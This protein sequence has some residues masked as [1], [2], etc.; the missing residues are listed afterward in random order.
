MVRIFVREPA[1]SQQRLVLDQ[2]I[3][4]RLIRVMRM[5]PG[6]SVEIVTAG[7]RWACKLESFS[8]NAAVVEI[9]H[10]LPAVP[11]GL[12]LVLAQA[13]PKGDRFEWL[14]EKATELGVS[15][16]VPLITERTIARPSGTE[17]KLQR[18]NKIAEQAAGQSENPYPTIV[19]PPLNLHEWI[20]KDDAELKC[21]LHEREGTGSLRDFLR[22]SILRAT[23]VV[24]PEGGWSNEEIASLVNAGYH[25]IH[26]GPR[27]LRSETAGLV[28]ASI[29]QYELGDFH[30]ERS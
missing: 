17:A 5:K 8:P 13:V 6:D 1:I 18:W 24:G 4:K 21:F 30:E 16:I 27:V 9:L 25:G 12:R 19:E 2:E 26:L 20:S 7:K 14:I 28:I 23:F 10:E 3:K 11:P 29:L 22:G 15:T